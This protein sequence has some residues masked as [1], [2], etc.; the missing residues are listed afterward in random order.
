MHKYLKLLRTYQLVQLTFRVELVLWF[1]IDTLP[2]G[3]LLFVWSSIFTQNNDFQGFTLSE[4][5]FYYL[6]SVIMRMLTASPFEEWRVDEIRDGK[7]DRYLIQP[8]GYIQHIFTQFVAGKSIYSALN[9]PLLIGVVFFFSKMFRFTLP[10]LSF[11]NFF[12]IFT[13]IIFSLFFNFSLG[14]LIVLL[15][16]WFE[17]AENLQHFKW[18]TVSLLS[19]QMLPIA[20]MPETLQKITWALPFK[21]LVGIPGMVALNKYTLETSDYL[22][23]L[24][25]LGL[26]YLVLSFSW[27]KAKYKYSS[28]G[29]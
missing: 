29:G 21:Y 12:P 20:L 13:L 24:V 4:I 6:L 17:N 16:F 15:G 5:V 22:Y 19:G 27:Q 14:L 26:C 1:I 3:I 18:V 7:I 11:D 8:V 2:L 10:H 28:V 25:T 23:M 9:L